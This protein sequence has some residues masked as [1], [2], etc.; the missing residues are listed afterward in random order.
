[1]NTNLFLYDME[2]VLIRLLVT[3]LGSHFLNTELRNL[4]IVNIK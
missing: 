1:M 4:I 2:T 3:C